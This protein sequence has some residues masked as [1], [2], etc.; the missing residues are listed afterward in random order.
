MRPPGHRGRLYQ[1]DKGGASKLLWTADQP[2][3]FALTIDPS[4]VV[5]AGTSPDGKVYRIEHGKA[6]EYFATRAH[7]TFW[8]LAVGPDGAFMSVRV[9]RARFFV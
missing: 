3:I 1:I 6:S 9:I 2:E 4:G 5:Y 8:S 7:A